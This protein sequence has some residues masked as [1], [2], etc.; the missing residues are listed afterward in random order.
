MAEMTPTFSG[1]V[2]LAG[3]QESHNS[4]C[5]VTF[6]L[7]DPDDL[8]A[9]RAMTVKK[10]NQSGQRLACVLVEIGDDE[11]PLKKPE[12]E[13]EVSKPGA[14]CLLAVQFCRDGRF[15][16]WLNTP[17]WDCL[18]RWWEPDLKVPGEDDA[19]RLICDICG[20]E[21]RKQLDTDDDAAAAF[22]TAI[23]IPFH[24]HLKENNL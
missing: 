18:S 14:L 16:K 17:E 6:W 5:K 19:R 21:S 22:H 8:D 1:E 20:I 23:R 12:Q 2:Q 24:Q 10:G 15:Q 7:A 11:Q 9:F 13:Q 3:W 4:G